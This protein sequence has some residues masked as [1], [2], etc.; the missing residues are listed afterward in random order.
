MR[1]NVF[2][3]LSVG[4][5]AVVGAALLVVPPVFR[6]S[7]SSGSPTGTAAGLGSCRCTGDYVAP[8]VAQPKVVAVAVPDT[9][10]Y[11]AKKTYQ[12]HADASGLQVIRVKDGTPVLTLSTLP[13]N[14]GFSPDEKRFVTTSTS[15]LAL[16]DLTANGKLL[17]TSDT[18]QDQDWG[19]SPHGKYLSAFSLSSQV[20]TVQVFDATTGDPVTLGGSTTQS[21]FTNIG[22]SPDDHS[23]LAWSAQSAKL[24]NLVT[25]S[26]VWQQ[27]GP[28]AAYG[29]SPVGG[30]LEIKTVTN[31]THV[32]LE[33]VELSNGSPVLR[34]EV[35]Q[36]RRSIRAHHLTAAGRQ[37]VTLSRQ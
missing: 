7:A 17:H 33:V 27:N 22:F 12:V 8:K 2:R 34:A 32:D 37:L 15:A 14:W 20:P 30:Y 24:F 19:F 4:T 29:F 35:R 28:P 11:S 21:G 13:T 6:A 16:Y 9:D 3:A 10:G 26:A 31:T 23:L 25:G 5:A 18:L 36:P 1:R